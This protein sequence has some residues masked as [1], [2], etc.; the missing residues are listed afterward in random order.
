MLNFGII[1]IGNAGNQVAALA[2]ERLNIDAL[3]I[4]SSQKDLD[5]LNDRVFKVLI[6][7][8]MGAGKNRS[9][10]KSFVKNNISK[11][12]SSEESTKFFKSDSGNKDFVF[13]VSSTG[14]GTGSGAS[15]VLCEVMKQVH[16]SINFILI[17]I[18][19]SISEA[20][21]A[22]VNTLE[23]FKELYDVDGG[24]PYMLYDNDRMSDKPVNVMM[25]SIN[26]AIVEDLAV[27]RGDYQ[28]PTKYSSIDEKDA[29]NILTTSGRIIVASARNIKEKDLDNITIDK[30]IVDD[31]KRNA[32]SEFNRDKIVHRLGIISI[33]DEAVNE[34][35]DGQ[36]QGVQEFLGAPVETYSHFVVKGDDLDAV[37][38]A[39]FVVASGLSKNNDRIERI[40]KRINDINELQE[41]SKEARDQLSD[42]DIDSLNAKKQVHKASE[43]AENRKVDASAIFAKY[44]CE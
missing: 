9:E 29:T 3:C 33:L 35:F 17:G 15:P 1:G 13:I 2:A 18:L 37:E 20:L 27:M 14:G 30:M 10:A 19:P 36:I 40:V 28:Y 32:H 31:M 26:N 38:N 25:E 41:K 16:S 43:A 21:S 11:L 42:I 5:T 34:H 39:V 12:L 44:G 24:T 4:N 23:Y 7:D 22:Q 6:G 8:S